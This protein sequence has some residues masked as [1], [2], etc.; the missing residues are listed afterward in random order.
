MKE[1]SLKLIADHIADWIYWVDTEGKAMFH[2]KS[3]EQF[4]EYTLEE[5]SQMRIF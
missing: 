1:K 3:V 2:S 4:T 5:I